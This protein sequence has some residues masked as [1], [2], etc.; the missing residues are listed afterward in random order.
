MYLSLSLSF[1]LVSSCLLITPIKGLKGHKSLG[2][3]F[4]CQSVKYPETV[5]DSVTRSPIELFWTAKKK[6]IYVDDNDNCQMGPMVGR[7]VTVLIEPSN[8]A[9]KV[10]LTKETAKIE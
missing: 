5:S 9:H 1:F 3:L 4:V 6:V 2:S 8:A 10:V 7:A